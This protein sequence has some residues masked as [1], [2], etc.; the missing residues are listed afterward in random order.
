MNGII[1]SYLEMSVDRLILVMFGAHNQSVNYFIREV[2][3]GK[4]L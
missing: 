3:V 1:R 2:I 4:D